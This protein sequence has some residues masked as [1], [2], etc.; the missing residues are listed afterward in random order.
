[1]ERSLPSLLGAR[2]N[3]ETGVNPGPGLTFLP[4][5]RRARANSVEMVLFPTPPFPER[6]RMMCRTP[7]RF[8]GSGEKQ[9][10]GC[11][12]ERQRQRHAGRSSRSPRPVSASLLS[13]VEQLKARAH[14]NAHF[15][16][17]ANFNRHR[18]N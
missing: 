7:A 9:E 13:E 12:R 4:W 14:V 3:N 6:T 10:L 16:L 5:W 18:G 15:K 8:P 1:V 2:D 11:L 17:P